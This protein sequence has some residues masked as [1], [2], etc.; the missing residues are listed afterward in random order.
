MPAKADALEAR[1]TIEDSI[2]AKGVARSGPPEDVEMRD[3]DEDE[4][5][6]GETD[7]EGEEDAEGEDDDEEP[8]SGGKDLLETIQDLATFLCAYKEE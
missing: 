6:D 3:P 5:A 2:E 7:A 4:D 1:E 8:E